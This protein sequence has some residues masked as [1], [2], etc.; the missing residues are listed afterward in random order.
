MR[1]LVLRLRVLGFCPERR[2]AGGDI[3]IHG[4]GKQFG[5]LGKTHVL[6]DWTLGCIAVT[7]E[8]IDEI[9]ARANIGAD[10]EIF[11]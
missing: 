11:P 3:K 6:Q 10:I 1:R 7:N 5:F 9:Y 2:R 4:L 8:E